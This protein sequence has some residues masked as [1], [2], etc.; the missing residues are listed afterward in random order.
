MEKEQSLLYATMVLQQ[1]DHHIQ[2]N[3]AGLLPHSIYKNN[4]KWI[5][6]YLLL[7]RRQIMSD[8]CNPMDCSLQAPPFMGFSRQ[9]YWNG[10]PIPSPGDLA[11]QRLN[12]HHLHWQADSLPLSH[13]RSLFKNWYKTKGCLQDSN[14][15]K[16]S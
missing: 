2:K 16:D 3:K 4:S 8:L 9:E 12:P 1:P 6:D 15:A 11:T 7:F 13:Q 5:I 10:L 14:W